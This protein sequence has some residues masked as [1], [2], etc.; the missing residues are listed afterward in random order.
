MGLDQGRAPSLGTNFMQFLGKIGQIITFRAHLW[1]WG[2]PRLGDLGSVYIYASVKGEK[3]CPYSTE[4][5]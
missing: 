5:L 4:W 3:G 1:S 2:A